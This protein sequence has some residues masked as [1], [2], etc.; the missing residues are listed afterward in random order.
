MEL[1]VLLHHWLLWSCHV[2]VH[3][4]TVT[5]V[6]D[7]FILR[8]QKHH[9]ENEATWSVG[10]QLISRSRCLFDAADRSGFVRSPS[11]RLKV[12]VWTA[13]QLSSFLW[14]SRGRGP[15]NLEGT[16]SLGSW[17]GQSPQGEGTKETLSLKSSHLYVFSPFIFFFAK[18]HFQNQV[19]FPASFGFNPLMR[20]PIGCFSP[21]WVF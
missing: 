16:L 14:C 12:S 11:V 7:M 21:C 18:C 4:G 15:I 19:S 8:S 6:S 3:L 5:L 10:F 2:S 17:K 20:I 1:L 13:R 9:E